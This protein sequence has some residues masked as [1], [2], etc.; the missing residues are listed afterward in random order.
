MQ[1]HIYNLK[2]N[3]PNSQ[4]A[5]KLAPIKRRTK[6]KPNPIPDA[7]ARSSATPKKR[8]RA[9]P[10]AKRP[11]KRSRANYRLN[12][13][14]VS[15]QW[16]DNSCWLDCLFENFVRMTEKD[17]YL[18]SFFTS[19]AD[20][21]WLTPQDIQAL[22]TLPTM[23][24]ANS[25][26]NVSNL[27]SQLSMNAQQ[28]RAFSS[29]IQ[30]PPILPARKHPRVVTWLL[31]IAIVNSVNTR[32]LSQK[33][34]AKDLVHLAVCHYSRAD[35]S[36]GVKFG[37]M[38]NPKRVLDRLALEDESLWSEIF[39]MRFED[40]TYCPH[41]QAH[42]SRKHSHYEIVTIVDSVSWLQSDYDWNRN[43]VPRNHLG[44]LLELHRET[45]SNRPLIHKR[46][47]VPGCP[48]VSLYRRQK[49]TAAYCLFFS[50]LTMRKEVHFPDEI[51]LGSAKYI[52]S[53][54][55][56]FAGLHFTGGYATRDG[57][58]WYFNSCYPRT[59]DRLQN[60]FRRT[61]MQID[62][63]CYTRDDMYNLNSS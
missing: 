4:L 46:C 44:V 47:R 56:Y 17:P 22:L 39:G 10:Q 34:K 29:R 41:D 51:F 9:G 8:K 13:T 31:S 3:N 15:V 60:G 49:G 11:Q 35:G 23:Y 63:V 38:S 19:I 52:L 57:S 6:S 20:P 32:N 37:A 48:A 61:D 36:R 59:T 50:D 58:K 45:Y 21:S 55:N 54:V 5:Q 16:H 2:R 18:L 24:H 14:R 40:T 25:R 12:P 53:S 30:Q 62:T 43:N 26:R 1:Q 27:T 42:P 28:I 7:T 33:T